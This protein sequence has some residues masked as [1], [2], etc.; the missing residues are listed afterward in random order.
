MSRQAFVGFVL[1]AAVVGLVVAFVYGLRLASEK[2][3]DYAPVAV[4]TRAPSPAPV[5]PVLEDPRVA[6][7][8][9]AIDEAG[10]VSVTIEARQFEGDILFEPPVMQAGG[11]ELRVSAQSLKDARL[12]LLDAIAAGSAQATFVFEGAPEGETEGVLIF[13]PSSQ[14]G[15]PVNPKISLAVGWGE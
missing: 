4:V 15:N 7:L 1:G 11:K 10:A 9:A 2:A 3:V 14:P 5:T 12:A 8:S 13:N 6:V